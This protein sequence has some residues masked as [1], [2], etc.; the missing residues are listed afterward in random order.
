V[1]LYA[2]LAKYGLSEGVFGAERDDGL[3]LTGAFHQPGCSLRNSS[4][5]PA[6]RGHSGQ[7]RGASAAGIGDR[8]A[9][10]G[11]GIAPS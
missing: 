5:N 8:S 11:K 9:G 3:R 1:L 10:V 7:S 2:T 4:R 6:S